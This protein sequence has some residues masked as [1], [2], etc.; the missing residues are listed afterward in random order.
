[1]TS[2]R[3]LYLNAH[4][5]SACHWQGGRLSPEGSFDHG[6]AGW[7]AFAA[8]LDAHRGSRFLL[9]A[10]VADE[11]HALE[12]VPFLRGRNRQALIQ[13]KFGQHF[14]GTPLATATSLGYEKS[15]RKNEQLL[16]SALTNPGQFAPWLGRL[17][18]AEVA[19]A[20]IYS[21]SQLGGP[22]LAR[23]GL[24]HHRCLLL[25][26]QG[27][28]IRESFIVNGQ[29]HFSRL[30]PMNERSLATAFA[31][32][33]GKLHQYLV[34]Q[35]LL[36]RDDALTAYIVA[37]PTDLPAIEEACPDAA[38]LSFRLIDNQ[39]AA[40]RLRLHTRPDDSSSERLFLH[41][42]AIAPPRRQFAGAEHR[43]HFH[44]SQIRHGLVA[45]GLS[46]LLAGGLFAARESYHAHVLHEET[47]V[48]RHSEAE[49]NRQYHDIQ[50][51][52]PSSDIDLAA[53][54]QLTNRHEQLLRQ[55]RL[56]GPAFRLLAEALDRNPEV[57]LE[58]IDWK[59]GRFIGLTAADQPA[60]AEIL[61]IR[62]T[63]RQPRAGTRQALAAF[64]RFVASLRAQPDVI[65]AVTQR[66]V[67][68]E[69]GSTLQGGDGIGDEARSRPFAIDITRSAAP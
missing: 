13:R 53:L 5:L 18:E 61:S 11:G 47:A 15:L 66:P 49:L 46:A 27:Q 54:R 28:A 44:L 9:L 32:E 7:Q 56:P 55:Q 1:M 10:D 30:A 36:G 25:S 24:D 64:D 59:N 12:T 68:I 38:P 57:M 48:L 26:L 43:H 52:F 19:L 14:L 8:Y 58:G 40:D 34:G 62:A 6:E 50:A 31:T 3:L 65:I 63:I 42:L 29:T 67:D 16:L 17:N 21:A 39:M 4:R 41:L 51:T 35:R 2:R 33:A 69:P 60:S 20:G 22:L 23:L 37:H 45:M